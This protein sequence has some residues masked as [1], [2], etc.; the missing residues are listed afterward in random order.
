MA[1]TSC[2]GNHVTR[3][4]NLTLT[5]TLYLT[6][7]HLAISSHA[8]SVLLSLLSLSQALAYARTHAR[9]LPQT[10]QPS[11]HLK[12]VKEQNTSNKSRR[13]TTYQEAKRE[14]GWMAADLNRQK[15]VRSSTEIQPVGGNDNMLRVGLAAGVGQRSKK[16]EEDSHVWVL[17]QILIRPT[18]ASAHS[19]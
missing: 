14:V 13:K 19:P 4:L 6:L 5:L 17:R 8:V 18:G 16:L 10:N 9:V 11:K 1:P 2:A 7:T 15:L 12:I 3:S